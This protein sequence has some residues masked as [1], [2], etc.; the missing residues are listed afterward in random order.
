L[1]TFPEF[2]KASNKEA[3]RWKL[4]GFLIKNINH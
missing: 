1:T 4:V 3:R 2:G